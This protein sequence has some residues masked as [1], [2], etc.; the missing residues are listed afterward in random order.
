MGLQCGHEKKEEGSSF[1]AKQNLLFADNGRGEGRTSPA[2]G[3]EIPVTDGLGLCQRNTM[4]L[5]VHGE[6]DT[7]DT[8]G[9]K[10][11]PRA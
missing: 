10:Q 7:L 3:S 2:E 11:A 1:L 8:A 4:E 6:P 9:G 5:E